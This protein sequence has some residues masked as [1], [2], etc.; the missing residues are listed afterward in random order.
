MN[1]P[2][3]AMDGLSSL[4]EAIREEKELKVCHRHG[5]DVFYDDTMCPA[6]RLLGE[7][8]S[9]KPREYSAKPVAEK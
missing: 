4:G 6:C 7:F 5:S 9:P 8:F 1:G 3:D 2:L